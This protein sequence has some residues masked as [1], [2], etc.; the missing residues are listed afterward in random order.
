[1]K[2]YKKSDGG[3]NKQGRRESSDAR[4]GLQRKGEE[5]KRKAEPHNSEA[6]QEQGNEA[7]PRKPRHENFDMETVEDEKPILKSKTPTAESDGEEQTIS[8]QL[9][10]LLDME[11][12]LWQIGRRIRRVEN[13]R[14]LN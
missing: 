3:R 9:S 11:E 13:N 8:L 12:A 10:G 1:M 14:D 4:R 2:D 5:G 6:L 7:H